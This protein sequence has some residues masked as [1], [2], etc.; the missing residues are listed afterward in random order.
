[1]AC[2]RVG[3]D[4]SSGTG[5]SG[6]AS[7]CIGHDEDGD[8]IADACDV[9]PHIA[10]ADQTDGDGDAVGDACDP[11][12]A[13]AR[14]RI[15]FFDPFV[16]QLSEW[17]YELTPV[18]SDDSVWFDVRTDSVMI[19]RAEGLLEDTCVIGG[20]VLRGG[21][22]LRQATLVGRGAT[23][24][25]YCELGDESEAYLGSTYTTDGSSFVAATTPLDT[26]LE[27]ADIS[28]YFRQMQSSLECRTSQNVISQELPDIDSS[29]SGIF[30]QNIEARLDFYIHITSD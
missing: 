10:D 6:D 30:L 29:S 22:L 9:C 18:F 2:G 13:I 27:N 15:V 19:Q 11:N 25:Y 17:S 1:M 7:I 3:F 12:P 4:P 28:L 23:G 20:R 14:D 8:G 5:N 26:R 16:E 21:S 24:Y